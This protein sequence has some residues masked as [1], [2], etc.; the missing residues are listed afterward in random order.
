MVKLQG[1]ESRARVDVILKIKNSAGVKNGRPRGR[2]VKK[3]NGGPRG[4]RD[5]GNAAGDA[6]RALRGVR[7]A[8]PT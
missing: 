2:D 7:A 3:I 5:A 8:A 1:Y 6:A 4:G